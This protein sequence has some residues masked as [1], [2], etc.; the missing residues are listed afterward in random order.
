[1]KVLEALA[2][3]LIVATTSALAVVAG[4]MLFILLKLVL[5]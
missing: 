1:M 4:V 3:G 5:G 2:L